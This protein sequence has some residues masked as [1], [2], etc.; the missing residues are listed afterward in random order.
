MLKKLIFNINVLIL[1]IQPPDV[2]INMMIS[3]DYIPEWGFKEGLR[4]FLQN[5]H[6]GIINYALKEDNLVIKGIGDKYKDLL[7]VLLFSVKV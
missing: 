1:D 5:Q 2:Q 3:E 4:E 6:D 7:K